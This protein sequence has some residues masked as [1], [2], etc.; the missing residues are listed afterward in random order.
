MVYPANRCIF[1]YV[2]CD[3]D[4]EVEI[5]KF[6]DR[7]ED[8]VA[9]SKIVPKVGFYV[10]YRDSVG[11]LRLYYPDFV[12][13]TEN[14]EYFV[15]EAKGREDIDVEYKDKRIKLWCEDATKLTK[16][17]WSF[18][19]VDQKDFERYRFRNFK[20]MINTLKKSRN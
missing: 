14:E 8:V 20:E 18:M 16:S 2:P 11:N 10:E 3:N 5:A 19:R 4:F 15:I 7:A 6:L 9:F 1:N 13:L 17:N 12:A